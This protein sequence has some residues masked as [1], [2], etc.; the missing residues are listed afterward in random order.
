MLAAVTTCAIIKAMIIIKV[1]ALIMTQVETSFSIIINKNFEM[2]Q[3]FLYGV[4]SNTVLERK[5]Y[6]I[7]HTSST[8]I[9]IF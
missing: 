4:L 6:Y 3:R 7:Y 1:I 5:C 8:A 9:A 2:L